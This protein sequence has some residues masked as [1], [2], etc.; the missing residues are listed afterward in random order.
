MGAWNQALKRSLLAVLAV[1]VAFAWS[2]TG[3]AQTSAPC[4]VSRGQDPL[5]VL[6]SGI[7]HNVWVILDTSGSMNNA[8]ASG[9]PA[10]IQ[11]AKDALNRL[12]D[13]L[14]DGA[15]RPLV[16][17]A[18]VSYDNNRGGGTRCP[19]VP[20]DQNGD[21]YPDAP[22]ACVGLNDSS[23]V[24]PGT[25]ASDS[26]ADVRA[27]LDDIAG[28][29]GQTPIGTSFT[30]I[31][32]YITG[33]GL[34]AANTTSFVDNLLPNQ[35]NYIIHLTDGEDTCE[36]NAGGYPGMI[37][38]PL[39]NPVDMR[40]SQADPD[41]LVST[42]DAGNIASYNA[43]LKGEFALKKIDP[44][45][46]GSKGNIFVIGFDIQPGVARDRLNTIAWMSSGAH[47]SPQRAQN[48]MNPAFFASGTDLV[49]TFRDILARIGIPQTE[50][51]LGAPIVASVREVIDTHTDTSVALADVFPSN[52][53]DAEAIRQARIIRADHRD[54]V[55]FTASVEVPSFRGHLRA[56]NLYTVTD[57]DLPRTAREEDLTELWDAG[58]EL[59]GVDPDARRL[60]FNRRGSTD[61][62]EF[63][64]GNVTPSDLSVSAGFLGALTD[65]DARDMVVRVVRGERLVRDPTTGT[66]YDTN[67]D[68]SFTKL[69]PDGEPTWKL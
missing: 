17:W 14:V 67:G 20:P 39:E 15:G 64:T 4:L 53:S 41:T 33:D 23:F 9:G 31:A 13:E 8:P 45:L 16:N 26:R 11:I 47:L 3:R 44:Q 25:C 2:S 28:G 1:V 42:T 59:Q 51:T 54:N 56:T 69:G 29:A 58:V 66:Y 40:P 61:L 43:G 38:D 63:D 22:T 19:A 35:K 34:T 46:D 48:L 27:K 5:D 24:Q 7:R 6:N 62:L 36:C 50:V 10:K 21:T 18:F 68:L 60:F 57:S 52:L 37:G 55:L 49:D 30:Q 65:E 12:M 32:S